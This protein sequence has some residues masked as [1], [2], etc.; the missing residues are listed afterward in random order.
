MLLSR[1]FYIRIDSHHLFLHLT[2]IYV[3]LPA[4][5]PT[6]ISSILPHRVMSPVLQTRLILILP[7]SDDSTALPKTTYTQVRIVC[8]HTYLSY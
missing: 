7:K 5:P 4:E 8:T 2:Q 6:A 3:P 1:S